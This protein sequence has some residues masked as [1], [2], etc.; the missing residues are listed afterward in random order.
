MNSVVT[1]VVAVVSLIIGVA[2]LAVLV[3][4]NART[5]AVISSS[6]DA[7]SKVLATAISP[8]MGGGTS[9]A[10]LGTISL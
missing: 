9:L 7:L 1:Q 10:N 8:V 4:P 3:A 5:S 6:G 2:V